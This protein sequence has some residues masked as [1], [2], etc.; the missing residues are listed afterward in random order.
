MIG[1]R[2][3]FRMSFIG[4]GS[5]LKEFYTRSPGSVLST[6]INKYMYI[7]VHPFFDN[8]IQVKYSKTE[9]VDQIDDVI[10]PI[11][12]E[13][14]KKF[15]LSGIDIN[16]I[17]DIPAGTGLG[18]SSSYT[19]GLLH[20]LYGYTNQNISAETLASEASEIEIEILKEPIGKQ[21][22]YAAAYGGL[23]I[24]RFLPTG[25]VKIEPI[26]MENSLY[27]QLQ[28]NLLLFYTDKTRSASDILYD[29]KNNLINQE[30]IFDTQKKMTKLVEKAKC[31]LSDSDLDGFGKILDENWQLKR[32]L[33]SKISNTKIDDI[34]SIALKN[35]AMGGKI[36]GAGGGGF[37]LFYC[38]KEHQKQLRGAL[39]KLTEIEFNFEPTGS[40]LIYF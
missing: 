24:I 10:H 13:S 15:D 11:V 14:L 9:L 2:T 30:K 32:S 35:R 34:Y 1:T 19:V 7:F 22:Q 18:S 16:S 8:R 26:E 25:D 29:Q 17:A 28:D 37:L 38:K 27:T 12:R 39:S 5:D 4:G 40:Q 6:T 20:A 3:P 21:D 31:C 33:S 23:N 36:L